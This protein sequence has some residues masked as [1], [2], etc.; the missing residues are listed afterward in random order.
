MIQL[1]YTYTG[2]PIEVESDG[3]PVAADSL[4]TAILYRNGAASGVTVTIASTAVTG[5]Y[6][7]SF[8]TLG[9]GDGWAKTDRLFIRAS[10]VIGGTTYEAIIWNSFSEPD[11]VMRGTDGANTVA[12]ATPANVTT[13]TST[14]TALLPA[15]LV[16]GRMD[17]SVGSNLDKTGY[18][19]SQSFPANFATL[20][21]NASGHVSRVTLVDTTTTNTDMRGT[22]GA[23]T[24]IPSV[25]LATT[26]PSITWQPQTITA[27]DG[28]P[29]IT[30]AGSGNADGIAWTRSGSGDPLDADIVDQIQSGLATSAEL[31][32]NFDTLVITA[33]DIAGTVGGIAGTITTLDDL[34]TAQ[35]TQH[36]TTRTAVT[37]AFTEIKGA[38]WSGT[39]DTLEAIR[40]RGDAAWVTGSSGGGTGARTV[41]IT[42]NDGTDPLENAIVRMTE[43]A[44][45][46]TATTDVSG[47]ATFNLDDATYVVSVSKSGYSY[48]GTTLLV[49]GTEAETYSMTQVATSPPADPAL[50]AV[51]IHVRDQYGVDLADEPVEITFV[52]WGVGAA[53][54]VPVLSPPPVQTTD[55]DGTVAVNLYRN[56]VYKIIYG[57]ADYALRANVT[58]PDAGTYEVT[59]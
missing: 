29:N 55:V 6:L 52:S 33:G 25:T 13:S 57:S 22:D 42:I 47:V 34:D 19:L 59:I 12:P 15:A 7:A 16:G 24:S 40:D 26:Q 18:S 1:E 37:T 44:N 54:T 39:T 3:E 32:A 46:Y 36:G 38:T 11:A 17:A 49:N 2:I 27:G 56:A 48:S 41:T 9:A 35:D 31:P 30:L 5:L 23:V 14:I 53:D 4:P 28:N 45:T 43:G 58:V 20:A 50:C 10:A 8:T 51:T 21:I